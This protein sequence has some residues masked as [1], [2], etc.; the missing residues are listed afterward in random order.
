MNE[1]IDVSGCVYYN[2]QNDTGKWCDLTCE[3]DDAPAFRCEQIKNCVYKQMKRLEAKNAKHKKEQE[4]DKKEITYLKE[5]C[6]NAGKELSK[7]SF[8]WDGKEKNLVVQALYLNEKYEK[9][10]SAL[11]KV[12]ENIEPCTVSENCSTCNFDFCANKDILKIIDEVLKDE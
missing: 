6:I 10:E 5:C 9:L 11:K 3:R 8:K 2:S 4:S 1:E 12:K 7:H